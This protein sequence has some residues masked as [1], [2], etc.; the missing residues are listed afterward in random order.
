MLELI[1]EKMQGAFATVIVGFFCAAFALW[2]VESLFSGGGSQN[3]VVTVN[4]QDIFEPEVKNAVEGMRRQYMKMLGGQVDASF[5]NDAMLRQPALESLISRRLLESHSKDLGMTVGRQTVDS[6][7]VKDPLFSRDGGKTFDAEYYKEQLRN[8]GV[9]AA[10]YQEQLRQ[11]LTL[12]HLQDGIAT[13]TFVTQAQVKDVARLAAQ[14]RTFEYLRLPVK[15]MIESAVIADEAIAQYYSAHQADFMSEEKLSIEYVEL[16]K[17]ALVG[18]IRVDEADVRAAYDQE[19]ATFK[20][21]IER[22]AAHILI[23]AEKDG[24]QQKKIDTITERLSKGTDF[25]VLAKEYSSDEGSAS[26][27][28][29]VGFTAGDTFVA[30]FEQALAALQNTGDVSAPVKTEFGYHIIK[31]LEQR[32]TSAPVFEKRKPELETQLKQ[33]QVNVVF[34]EK[35]DQLT[36]SSY[37]SGDLSGSAKEL[38]LVV[39]KTATFG[40]RGGPGIA[41]QQ[42]VIEA[43][44]SAD[45][46]DSGKNSAVIELSADQ[47]VVLRVLEHQLPVVRELAEVKAT[48]L[49]KLK[50]EQAGVALQQKTQALKA[51][52]QSE[53]SLAGV[54]S[55]EKQKV[56]SETGKTRTAAG[57]D[58]DV[59]SAV[60]RLPKPQQDKA[61]VDAVTLSGGDWVLVRLI[62]VESVDVLPGSEEWKSAEQRLSS[63]QGNEQ[64]ST[65]EQQLREAAKIVRHDAAA[66]N[67]DSRDSSAL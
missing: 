32:E 20:P 3:A 64:F 12:S 18:A 57:D 5:L 31:L 10:S 55:D 23:A 4:G 53:G 19:I 28:G 8:A 40:R 62:A 63:T 44:F 46:V 9:S 54:A 17:A 61:V 2:G 37:S 38:D 22:H 15:P 66:K 41:G 42:K 56:L 16:N 14:K 43:A 59:F 48:I 24:S 65:V 27:G 52:V 58:A 1:R 45:L 51:R 39:Q 47:A 29:D 50:L 67:K 13:S 25:S 35:L 7:I 49:D 36:E 26:Q 34:S 33:A 21:V 60:F 11:Q 6:S 30:E